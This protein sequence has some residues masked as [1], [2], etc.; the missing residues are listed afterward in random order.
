MHKI[1]D[2]TIFGIKISFKLTQFNVTRL[3]RWMLS[4]FNLYEK[5]KLLFYYQLICLDDI[6]FT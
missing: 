3:L 4:I 1:S 2:I 6:K 5:L